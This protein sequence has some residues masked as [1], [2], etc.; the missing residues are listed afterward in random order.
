[1]TICARHQPSAKC[2]STQTTG[3]DFCKI[4]AQDMNSLYLLSLVLIA[5]HRLAEQCFEAAMADCVN[6]N[7]VFKQWARA[8]SHRA[9]IKN[10]IR[11]LSSHSQRADAGGLGFSAADQETDLH[12]VLASITRLKPLERFVYVMSG[13]ERYSD[14]ECAILLDTTKE[15]VAEARTR[16]MQQLSVGDQIA[17]PTIEAVGNLL[18]ADT[19]TQLRSGG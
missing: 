17:P 14:H 18:N 8:W 10:A 4:F 6:G 9:I 3:D 5:D 13:L 19:Y 11:I 16:A 7:S 2:S 12:P 1:M 15:H